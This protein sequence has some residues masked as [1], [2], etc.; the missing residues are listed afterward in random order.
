MTLEELLEL[1]KDNS[2]A[3]KFINGLQDTNNTNVQ[4]INKN[5]TL[6]NNLKT[7]LDKFK[8]GNSL[9]KEKLGLDQLNGDTLSE[10][11]TKLKSGKGDDGLKAEI[12]NLQKML[13]DSNVATETLKSDFANKERD[14][15][16]KDI[17]S[18]YVN[19]ESVIPTARQDV[20]NRIRNAM[21]YD[22]NNQPV[23]LNEDGTTKYIN[24]Q[25]ADFETMYAEV[26]TNS[27]HLFKGETKSGSDAQANQGGSG[28][29]LGKMSETE[30]LE[31]FRRDPE[32]FNQLK[33][34]G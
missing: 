24:G 16:T 3:T 31:L 34:Q 13:N 8:A 10:A 9:V 2:E 17:I 28:Q 11:L 29:G 12:E 25:K 1:V 14:W 30:R 6:I 15:N 7:D 21:S 32:K 27:P 18:K 33:K 4:T 26:K 20:E 19:H 22:E 5:E 23:F